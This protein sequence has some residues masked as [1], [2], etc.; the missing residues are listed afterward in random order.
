MGARFLFKAQ[1]WDELAA[2]IPR[3]KKVRAAIAYLGTGG[4]KLLPLR[5]GDELVVDMSLR[6]V[7][8]GV[9]NPSEVKK[10]LRRKVKVF[11]RETLHAKFLIIDRVVIAGSSNISSHAKNTLDEA[12]ILTDDAAVLRRAADTF[13]L[14]C[15]EPVRKEY[16]AK[17]LAEYRPPN[18]GGGSHRTPGEKKARRRTVWMIGGLRYADMA[19]EEEKRVAAVV[20]RTREKLAYENTYVDSLHYAREMNFFR[21]LAVGDWLLVGMRDESASD[22]YPPAQYLGVERYTRGD[23]KRGYLLLCEAPRGAKPVP[24]PQLRK[25]AGR[26]LAR[27]L[28]VNLRT[29]P[30][31][32]DQDG[33]A[34]LRLWDD[35]GQWRGGA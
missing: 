21:K 33:D 4:S 14:L 25:A 5:A 23:G 6:A 10:L 35:R 24:W 28:G 22:V 16:L 8:S 34:L 12:A 18:F 32:T 19:H 30:T 26:G 17:C 20:E 31:D 29:M 13:G 1:L 27:K 9:T 2:R 11:S 3:A 15:N 7:R